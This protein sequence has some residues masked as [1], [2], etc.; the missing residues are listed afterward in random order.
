M[1]A[2]DLAEMESREDGWS[3]RLGRP[4][5]AETPRVA[6]N[7][8]VR[9]RAAVPVARPAAASARR[10][11]CAP[12]FGIVYLAPSPGAAPFVAPGQRVGAGTTV[13]IIE[14]MKVFQEIKAGR[15]GVIEALA[16]TSG[17]EV[18]AGQVLARFA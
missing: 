2:P 11:L 1:A 16:V 4:G 7:S 13:C 14:A 10:D 3:L 6:S 9:A 12:M 17:E 8:P 18:E 5:K 15:D